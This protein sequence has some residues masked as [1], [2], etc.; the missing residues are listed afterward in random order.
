M[1]EV[2]NLDNVITLK[3]KWMDSQSVIQYTSKTKCIDM[4]KRYMLYINKKK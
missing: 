2:G 1:L 3:H 4:R